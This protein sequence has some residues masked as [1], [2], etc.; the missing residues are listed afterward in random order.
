MCGED[1]VHPTRSNEA[2]ER[3]QDRYVPLRTQCVMQEKD[4]T[5]YLVAVGA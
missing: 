5:P 4:K 2:E 3:P 1:S